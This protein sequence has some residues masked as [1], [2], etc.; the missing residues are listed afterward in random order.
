[1]QNI[2]AMIWLF[3]PIVGMVLVQMLTM[4]RAK[5][6]GSSKRRAIVGLLIA[7]AI[8]VTHVFLRYVAFPA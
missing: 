4:F 5:S 2:D 1:M 6:P 7:A 3:I 8:V